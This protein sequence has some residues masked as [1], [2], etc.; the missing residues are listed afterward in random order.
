MIS[1]ELP[2]GL[3]ILGVFMVFGTAHLNELVIGQGE[4]LFGILPRWGV[5]VQPLGFI[6]FLITVF[7]ETNRN[8]FDLPEGESE[9]LGFHVEYSGF[10]YVLFLMGEYVAIAMSGALIATLYFG[11]WQIPYM[12]TES[13]IA[14]A[15]IVLRVLIAG[16]FLM[17]LFAMFFF[18]G[19][20]KFLKGTW[21]DKRDNEGLIF[22]VLSVCAAVG[23]AALAYF[24]WNATLPDWGA[25]TVTVV[26]QFGMFF[27]KMFFF[28]LLFI[29]VRWTLPRF[30]YDQLMRLGWKNLV[31]LAFFNIF[32]TG[33]AL[34]LFGK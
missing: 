14:N 1:Y 23:F 10:R 18:A 28:C 21:N 34:L 22:V 15:G 26:A 17:S 8:P 29:W 27:I 30:R 16:G 3:S 9:I 31:P 19:Y 32:A 25:R 6:I 7:A 24:L 20:G 12:P 2:M 5:F 33:I 11:G 4:L 13:L